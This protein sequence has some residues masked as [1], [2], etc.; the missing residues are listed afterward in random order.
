MAEERMKEKLFALY[1]QKDWK[2]IVETM[3][4]NPGDKGDVV[5]LLDSFGENVD[6]VEAAEA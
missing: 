3:A 5:F 2:G 4:K 6:Y 1:E